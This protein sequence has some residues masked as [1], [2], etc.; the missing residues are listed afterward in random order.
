MNA[1]PPT[2]APPPKETLG[3]TVERVTFHNADNGFCVLK[4]HARGKRDLAPFTGHT[5]AIDAGEWA[6]ATGL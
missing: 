1:R 4:V 5:P 2:H 3:G 6:I